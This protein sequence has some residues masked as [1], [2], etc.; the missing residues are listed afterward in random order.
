VH[1]QPENALLSDLPNTIKDDMKVTIQL[2]Y[3]YLW[4][5]KY[6]INQ[7]PAHRDLATQLGQMDLIY[8]CAAVTIVAA[9]G[10]DAD[11]GLSGVEHRPSDGHPYITINSTVW[12]AGCLRTTEPVEDSK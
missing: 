2:G 12:V 4:V 1:S 10:N 11:Y 8:H 3:Q 7:N 6:C 9:A 5:D